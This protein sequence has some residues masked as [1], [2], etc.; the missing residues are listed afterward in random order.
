MN[1]AVGWWL[2]QGRWGWSQA[3]FYAAV[4]TSLKNGSNNTLLPKALWKHVVVLN[5]FVTPHVSQ[6]YR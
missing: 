4:G 6:A 2:L 3:S 1:G 5:E